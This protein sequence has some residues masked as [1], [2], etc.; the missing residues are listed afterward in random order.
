[1]YHIEFWQEGEWK[2]D[3]RHFESIGEAQK[4]GFV[5][6]VRTGQSTRVRCET[7]GWSA[8]QVLAGPAE[9]DTAFRRAMPELHGLLREW[10][11]GL[12]AAD[13]D[14]RA[15]EITRVMAKALLEPPPEPL[16]ERKRP[17]A[18]GKVTHVTELFDGTRITTTAELHGPLSERDRAVLNR[19]LPLGVELLIEAVEAERGCGS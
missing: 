16:P 4:E 5:L 2:P 14:L 1:M 18:N 12:A 6:A 19:L 8:F 11:P 9:L 3:D 7:V 15:S 17:M 10:K 13:L